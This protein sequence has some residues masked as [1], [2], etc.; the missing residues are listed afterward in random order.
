MNGRLS[1]ENSARPI[2]TWR[3]RPG[4][5]HPSRT[6]RAIPTSI[7][8]TEKAFRFSIFS[9]PLGSWGSLSRASRASVLRKYPLSLA[10]RPRF[11]SYAADSSSC[12]LGLVAK[13]DA[14]RLQRLCLN[15]FQFHHFG[16]R[17]E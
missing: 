14:S 16:T 8:R 5:V 10:P 7:T 6:G 12:S 17:F 13:E 1:C 15:Q 2:S 3:R 9:G 11:L 4:D